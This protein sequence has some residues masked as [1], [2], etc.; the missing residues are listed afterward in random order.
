METSE[1][2]P[3]FKK[4]EKT[5]SLRSNPMLDWL[6]NKILFMPGNSVPVGYCK[7]SGGGGGSSSYLYWS[8]WLYPSYAE[9]CRSCNVG[10]ISRARFEV[11]LMDIMQHQLKLN[12]YSMKE[13]GV[14]RINNIA[15]KDSPKHSKDATNENLYAGYPSI[16]ELAA[17][18]EEYIPI[19]GAVKIRSKDAKMENMPADM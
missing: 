14:L 13:N 10:I 6:D 2:V 5:Q 19:Y 11:L 17:N 12:V 18:P 9:F 3:F 8:E 4:Y 7:F 16:V 15:I 1:H